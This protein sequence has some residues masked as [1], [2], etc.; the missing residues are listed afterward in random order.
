[1]NAC[2]FWFKVFQIM[3]IRLNLNQR[4]KSKFLQGILENF[5][6]LKPERKSR[7]KYLIAKITAFSFKI[8]ED[9]RQ[10]LFRNAYGF[11]R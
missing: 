1:M 11:K 7:S 3:L 6:F 5:S 9:Q 10:N 2:I 4:P 8:L